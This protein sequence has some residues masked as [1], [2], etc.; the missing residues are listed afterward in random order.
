MGNSCK[1]YGCMLDDE[2][3]FKQLEGQR[4]E[5]KALLKGLVVK[6]DDIDWDTVIKKAELLHRRDQRQVAR[7]ERHQKRMSRIKVLKR[8]KSEKKGNKKKAYETVG[9]YSINLMMLQQDD[10][11]NEQHFGVSNSVDN[12]GDSTSESTVNEPLLRHTISSTSSTWTP[13]EV[14]HQVDVGSI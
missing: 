11:P 9:I 2:A 10:H 13:E 4:Q 3:W 12:S 1:G 5:G 8:K 6:S 14:H 7:R